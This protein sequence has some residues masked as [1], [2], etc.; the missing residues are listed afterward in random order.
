MTRK[1]WMVAVAIAGQV[2]VRARPAEACGALPDPD[3]DAPLCSFVKLWTPAAAFPQ[4]LEGSIRVSTLDRRGNTQLDHETFD[5]NVQLVVHRVVGGTYVAVPFT[6]VNQSGLVPNA[7]QLQLADPVPGTYVVSSSQVTCEAEPSPAG[8]G[9]LVG[10]F[11]IEAAVPLPATLGEL[12]WLGERSVVT[13]SSYGPGSSC[14]YTDVTTRVTHSTLELQLGAAALPWRDVIEA[15]VYV[16]GQPH[17]GFSKLIVSD[18]GV[19]TVELTRTCSTSD[20]QWRMT[21][22]GVGPGL[23]TIKL[24]GQ[25]GDLTRI[26][27]SETTFSLACDIEDDGWVGVGCE[28]GRGGQGPFALLLVALL[29]VSRA[30]R[31]SRRGA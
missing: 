11:E 28:S 16:D 3:R 15:G 31:G 7:R 27:S 23:H 24:V 2:A 25:I 4:Q 19:A 29:S 8:A 5:P 14:E 20:P 18:D 6:L 13:T 17:I 1:L 22:L 26:E 30:S 10:R 9:V 21:D 12:Q